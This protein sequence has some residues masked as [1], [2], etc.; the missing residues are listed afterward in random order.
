MSKN[1]RACLTLSEAIFS[2]EITASMIWLELQKQ[3]WNANNRHKIEDASFLADSSLLFLERKNE[4]AWKRIIH[5]LRISFFENDTFTYERENQNHKALYETETK[6]H[7]QE[8][9]CF[10]ERCGCTE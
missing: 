9:I 3:S 7:G 4:K 10:A 1:A 8:C 2:I 5:V 6:H